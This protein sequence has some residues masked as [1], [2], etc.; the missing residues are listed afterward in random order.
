MS[1]TVIAVKTLSF[2]FLHLMNVSTFIYLTFYY[3]GERG[4][5]HHRGC[6]QGAGER[7]RDRGDIRAGTRTL[8]GR[9]GLRS[10]RGRG[11]VGL[12]FVI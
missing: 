12:R 9:G 7:Q 5:H 1:M 3:Q 10:V 11:R 4:H 2:Y 8:R 6:L